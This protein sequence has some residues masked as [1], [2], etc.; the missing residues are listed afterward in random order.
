MPDVYSIETCNVTVLFLSLQGTIDEFDYPKKGKNIPPSKF[1]RPASEEHQG[2]QEYGDE[3]QS[4]Y[5]ENG[6]K[7][8]V[9]G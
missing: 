9:P 1:E 4:Y 5:D 8:E 3:G 7:I 6:E 2:D